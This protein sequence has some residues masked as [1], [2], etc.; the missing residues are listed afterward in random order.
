MINYD[1]ISVHL[2]PFGRK[3]ELYVKDIQ[4][5]RIIVAGNHLTNVKCFYQVWADRLGD[6]IVEYEGDSPA[7][8]PG[9]Q[10]DHSI[11][12]YTYDVRE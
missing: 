4:E 10:S 5:D 6:L 1:T 8:Y 7:D 2:T 12:G 9:N 11:A 3:D